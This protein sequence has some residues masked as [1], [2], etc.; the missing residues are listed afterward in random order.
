MNLCKGIEVKYEILCNESSIKKMLPL[1]NLCNETFLKCINETKY[2]RE[3]IPGEIYIGFKKN[4]SN[5]EINNF[6][7]G[8]K[9]NYPNI[10]IIQSSEF[11]MIRMLEGKEVEWI[12]K[13]K[14]NEIVSEANF[15]YVPGNV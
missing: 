4:V 7:L 14:E 6:I 8:L 1:C 10:E 12:F 5:D 2:D 9:S 11:Y 3:Y 15:I 13:L